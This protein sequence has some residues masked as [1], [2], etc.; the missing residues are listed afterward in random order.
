MLRT[1]PDAH[2]QD[3]VSSL[4]WANA[5]NTIKLENE[6]RKTGSDAQS[7]LHQANEKLDLLKYSMEELVKELPDS[8]PRKS[9]TTEELSLISN[10]SK[11]AALTGTLKVKVKSCNN[12]LEN[13][14]GRLKDPSVVLPGR[15]TRQG[16]RFSLMSRIRKNNRVGS[17]N[18]R[19][20]VGFSNEVRAQLKIDQIP[21]GSTSWKTVS[22][23]SWNETFK[24]E[25]NKSRELE[26]SLYWHDRRSL[27]ATKTLKLE[28]FLVNRKQELCLQLEPQGTLFIKVTF[29]SPF[30]QKRPK[31]QT[32]RKFFSK[33]QEETIQPALEEDTAIAILP[34][35]VSDTE[36][37]VPS[38]P[39]V[40]SNS[41]ETMQS[42]SEEDTISGSL[43]LP[44][45]DTESVVPSPPAVASNS[46]E[47]IHS[48]SEEDIISGSLPLPVSDTESVVPSLPAV[49]TDTEETSPSTSVEDIIFGSL[50]LPVSDT[51]RVVPSPP[52]VTSN[53]E[54][55]IQSTSEEDITFGSLPLPVS[56]TESVVPSL[57][58]VTNDPEEIIQSASEE[59]ITFGSLHL[60]VSDTE[61][62]VPSPPSVDT[63]TEEIIQ[64]ASEED[65]IS[66]SLPLPMFNT[67]SVES[68]PPALDTESEETIQS[69]SENDIKSDNSSFPVFDTESV[70]TSPPVYDTYTDEIIQSDED[71]I[72]DSP[73]VPEFITLSPESSWSISVSP[74]VTS[75]TDAEP[76]DFPVADRT[77]FCSD[78]PGHHI[79]IPD[80][81]YR[82]Y[83]A[84]QDDSMDYTSNHVPCDTPQLDGRVSNQETSVLQDPEQYE[85]PCIQR[86]VQLSLEDFQCLSVL[87]RGHFGKV[88]LVDHKRTNT[89]FALK[90]QKKRK[91]IASDCIDYLKHEKNIF[92]TV[93]RKRHPFLVNLF[94][95]F[96]TEDL[97]CFVM[98]YAAGGDLLSTLTNNMVAFTENRAM[99]YA[100]CCVLGLEFLH[101]KNI[102][103]RDLK[104]R[105]IV[106]DKDGYTK[107]TDFG[108]GKQGMGFHDRT[109]TFCGTLEYMA[110]EI[111]ERKPYTR[112]VD[113]WSLGVVIYVMLCG[114][115]PFTGKDRETEISYKVVNTEPDYPE[116]LSLE[117]LT[118]IK[119][120][121]NKNHRT[122]IRARIGPCDIKKHP[123]FKEMDWSALFSKNIIHPFVPSIAGPEDER[124]FTPP[125][126]ILTPP[127]ESPL[128]DQDLFQDFDWVSDWI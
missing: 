62:V 67:E 90:V 116:F 72:Y 88:L 92:Q 19:E 96:Q 75:D 43:P 38:P 9:I 54:E 123:F 113:W 111:F 93:S 26:L 110:P 101:K 124:A 33:K 39:A 121:M 41:E 127:E 18:I 107:I 60:P 34:L 31:L 46:E 27:C 97:V 115:F 74:V 80:S 120:L 21:M 35:P 44:V 100:A 98:E 76:K 15:R 5:L 112:S 61:R 64:S 30:I 106:V 37:V 125:D 89:T 104:L 42:A 102:A 16:G 17:Q 128:E 24:L 56:D 118:I 82:D 49:D 117:A 4:E 77:S 20:T 79:R 59:D 81:L 45:S 57:P 22:N 66:G 95:S 122:R 83:G 55:T 40:A 85:D 10:I 25:L 53:S 68:S 109:H 71:R 87:G 11:P 119:S 14:P 126:P 78:Q 103:H 58:A 32:I 12:I 65:I 84:C 63:D 69:A 1:I 70:E 52:A 36:S 50:P 105:N 99:F 48:A 114:R 3:G 8:H 13:V 47:T 7:I 73:P 28:E 108:L 86:G 23:P 29:S 6:R 91:I 94:A 2:L 51:E